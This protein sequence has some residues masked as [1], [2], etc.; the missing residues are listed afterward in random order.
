MNHWM[1]RCQDVSRKLSQSMDMDLPWLQRAA[2]RFHLMMCRYCTRFH[3]Q[4]RLLRKLSRHPESGL[5]TAETGESLSQDAKQRIQDLI[6][7]HST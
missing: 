6:R 3:D 2:I 4:L 1:F 5:P 7:Q